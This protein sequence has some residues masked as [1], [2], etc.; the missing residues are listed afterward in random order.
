[1]SC[2]K[3]RQ[4][5]KDLDCTEMGTEKKKHRRSSEPSSPAED[6]VKKKR[7]RRE[8]DGKDGSRKKKS[9]KSSKRHS[10]KSGE[11]HKSKSHKHKDSKKIKFEELSKDDYFSKNNE[12][13]SWLKEKKNMF[14]SDLSSEVAHGLFSDFVKAWNKG[15]LAS[16]YYEGISTGPRS[17]HNWN[18]KA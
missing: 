7:R 6:E 4:G 1:M 14:F 16:E 10:E 5:K 2:P 15:K 9:N 3:L 18:I 12:F 17:S 13:A 11:G 8:E